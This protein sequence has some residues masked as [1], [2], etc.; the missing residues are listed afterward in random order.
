MSSYPYLYTQSYSY[1]PSIL[2]VVLPVLAGL[3]T[4]AGGI[5]LY[6]LFVRKPNRFSGAVAKLHSILNFEHFFTESLLRALYCITV[7]GLVVYSV[8]LL[9]SHF[10]LALLLFVIGNLI[11]RISYEYAL[12]LLVLCRNTQEINRK[13]GPLPQQPVQPA[14]PPVQPAQ[15]PVQPAQP[16]VQPAQPPVPPTQPQTPPQAPVPPTQPQDTQPPQA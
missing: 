11:A 3:L 4:I 2:S 13:M 12:L 8:I 1:T 16:P 6:I 15:P 14:Q 7:V 9:F 5:A 10:F